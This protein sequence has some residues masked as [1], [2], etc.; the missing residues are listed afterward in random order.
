MAGANFSIRDL[1][2][3]CLDAVDYANQVIIGDAKVCQY[4]VLAVERFFDDFHNP[5]FY[6][7]FDAAERVMR[8]VQRMPHVKGPQANQPLELGAWQKFIYLNVFGWMM[9]TTRTRRFRRAY[10]EVPRGNGKSS[11]A[12][13]TGLYMLSADGEGGAE[14][15]SAAVTR[16]QAKI[17]FGTARS[18]ALRAKRFMASAGVE[19]LQHSIY[20]EKSASTF[21]PLSADARSLDG[22]NVHLAILDE[23]AQHKTREVYDVLETAMGK[24]AQSLMLMIT[25]AGPDQ[26][27][28]GFEIHDYAIKVLTGVLRDDNFFAVIY[29]V[30]E[31]D[32]WTDPESWEKANPNWGVSVMPEMIRQLANKA[33]QLPSSQN[34][35][36]MKHLNIWTNAAVSWLS[37][38]AWKSQGKQYMED[39]FLN[40]ECMMG[41]DLATKKDIV[42]RIKVFRRH[43]DG[44]FHYFIVPTLYLPQDAIKEQRNANYDGWAKD[45]HLILTPGNVTDFALIEE[46]IKKDAQKFA[47]K[48]VPYDPWQATQLAQNLS[49]E[50]GFQMIEFASSVRNFSEPMKEFEALVMQKRLWHNDNPVF[51]WMISNV[52]VKADLKGNIFP[53]KERE[54]NKIDGPVA[55]IMA[56]ARWLYSVEEE[57]VSSVYE[58]DN[59][60]M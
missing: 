29:T 28:I 12:A 30:D 53:R 40:E 8:F 26:G 10:G 51:N 59:I 36:K 54:Q 49:N 39:D 32:D 60:A 33:M 27:G 23:L 6:M 46:D 19:V 42:A 3:N 4:V 52:Q 31:G 58:S 2:P 15:Y 56:I 22:L 25:T 14:V 35:F 50:E 57:A 38:E 18:M 20:Q 17:V 7:D 48:D 11:V 21:L 37:M 1:P 34:S 16:D 44:V 41:L 5:D 45:G 55:A 43:I 24:R 13:P 9:R 47:L